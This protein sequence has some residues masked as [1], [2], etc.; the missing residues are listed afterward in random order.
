MHEI[1]VLEIDVI[2]IACCAQC[3]NRSI[4]ILTRKGVS[5]TNFLLYESFI[6]Q[7]HGST[8]IVAKEEIRYI[9]VSTYEHKLT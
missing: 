2:S 8:I 6:H 9:S 7:E 4:W 1:G 5:E 3:G